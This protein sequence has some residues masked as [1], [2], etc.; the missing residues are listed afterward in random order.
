MRKEKSVLALG[1]FDGVHRGH[2]ALLDACRLLADQLDAEAGAVTFAGHP[3]SLVLGKAPVLINSIADRQHLLSLQ[4]MTVIHALPFDQHL[5]SMPW[6]DFFRMLTE[7]LGAVGLVCGHDYRFGYRGQ[8][9][10]VLLQQ[11]CRES[12]I[13]CIVVPEQTIDGIRISSTHIRQLLTGGQMEEA[14]RFL[15]H[16]HLLSGR[17]VHG[18]AL[19]RTLGIPTANLT[20]PEGIVVPKFGVYACY[21][22]VDG[23]SFAAV[24]N[25]GTRPT[26]S[27]QGITVEPWLLDFDGDLYNREI[28]VE[29]HRFLRPE[30]KFTDLTALQTQIRLDA[31][32]TRQFFNTQL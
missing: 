8:G 24:A 16:P 3:E 10:A 23:R 30:M 11:A 26:V 7:E 32:Q 21:V 12:G 9:N 14:V 25:V 6:Q 4:G 29:F 20:V 31:E 15:G 18:H 1:F 22:T 2:Q 19:G 17:V 27:G 28:R 13:P 5:R